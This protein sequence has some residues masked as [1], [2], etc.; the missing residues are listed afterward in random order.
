[1]QSL[2]D[3]IVHSPVLISIDYE[4][5]CTVYLAIDS[6]IQGVRWILSQDCANGRR[7]PLRFGSISWN[8]HEL[9]YS[10]A[11]IELYRL[12]CALRAMCFHLVGIRNLV[13]EMDTLYIHGML[14]NPNMQPNAMINHWIAAILLFDFKLIHILAEK[15]HGPDGLSWHEPVD[16]EVDEDDDPEDWINRTLMS[17]Q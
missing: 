5:D 8:E 6:S 16:D 3:A 2:K 10:Q 15:H 9:R 11:K 12:F 13:V 4:T 1:M 17:E 7:R 14:N